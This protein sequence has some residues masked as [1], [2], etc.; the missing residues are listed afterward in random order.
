MHMHSS[1]GPVVH[2]PW[3]GRGGEGRRGEGRRW[4]GR[5]WKGRGG[6]CETCLILIYQRQTLYAPAVQHA[7]T[8]EL[9]LVQNSGQLLVIITCSPPTKHTREVISS[10]QWHSPHHTLQGWGEECEG[11]E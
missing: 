10:A 2:G 1:K 5:G 3:E 6:S 4:E 9:H 11:V 7:H 8:R